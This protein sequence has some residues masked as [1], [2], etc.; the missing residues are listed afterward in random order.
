M[1]KFCL[2]KPLADSFKKALHEGRIDPQKLADM[3]S[4]DRR[5]FLEEIVGKDNAHEVNALFEQ[6]SLLK[7]T[8]RGMIAW[9]KEVAGLKPE[10]RRGMIERI[11]K[12]DER[13]LNPTEQKAFLEDLAAKKLGVEVTMEEAQKITEL[14][15]N[16]AEAKTKPPA[17]DG[18]NIDY[19]IARRQMENFMREKKTES[20]KVSMADFRSAKLKTIGEAAKQTAGVMKSLKA[21][22]DVSAWFR[23]GFKTI[24]THPKIWGE[25]VGKSFMEVFKTLARKTSD[26]RVMDALVSEIWSRPESLDG[27]LDRMKLDIGTGEEAY[28]TSIQEKVPILGRAFKASEVA[29]NGFLTRLRADIARAEIKK[30][31]SMGVNMKDPARAQAIGQM[32]NELTGRSHRG[33]GKAGDIVNATMFSP[34]SLQANIDFITRPFEPGTDSYVRKQAAINLLKVVGGIASTMAIA[35]A[36]KPGSAELDPTSSD[37]GKIKV[38]DTRFDITGGQSS[39]LT[40][41]ARIK[42]QSSKSSVTG[43][44]TPLG[45]GYGEKSGSAVIGDFFMNKLSPIASEVKRVVVDRADNQGK[46]LTVGGEFSNAFMPL[47]ISNAIELI[48]SS[49]SNAEKVIAMLADTLGVATNTYGDQTSVGQIFVENKELAKTI[50]DLS[51]TVGKPI[52]F[53]NWDTSSA[54]DINEFKDKHSERDFQDAKARYD[55]Q[56]QT[57]VKEALDNPKFKAWSDENKLKYINQIDNEAKAKVFSQFNFKRGRLPVNKP[58]KL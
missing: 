52:S 23:Q 45:S 41:L 28:P 55:Y 35:N 12:L 22:L 19:G 9:A 27:T 29:Y 44:S 48:N 24:F 38:G 57:R 15:K 42:T 21:S 10:V 3:S 40:L 5:T 30:A 39:L 36:V 14:S 4:G 2:L 20:G 1:A 32:I 47:P 56:I 31:E 18:S 33:I 53:T 37:F 51:N 7:D 54:A 11:Q 13:I 8:Q 46:P 58:L 25:N 50:H 43:K 6:K 17:A 34:K 16:L 26:E 49:D